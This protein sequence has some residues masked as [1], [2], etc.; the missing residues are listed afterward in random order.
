MVFPEP[1]KYITP[2]ISWIHSF[3]F[4]KNLILKLS[5]AHPMCS[6][7][8]VC[9]PPVTSLCPCYPLSFH[10]DPS[11]ALLPTVPSTRPLTGPLMHCIRHVTPHR[12]PSLCSPAFLFHVNSGPKLL[13]C[14]VFASLFSLPRTMFFRSASPHKLNVDITDQSLASCGSSCS[15]HQHLK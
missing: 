4:L 12:P 9:L 10:T 11:G 14:T 5:C 8:F 15:A 7:S 6:V 3:I 1:C 13:M 2:A